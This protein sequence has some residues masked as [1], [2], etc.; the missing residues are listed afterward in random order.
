MLLEQIE[1][2]KYPHTRQGAA[3]LREILKTLAECGGG[4][5]PA[6]VAETLQRCVVA[7][8]SQAEVI[9]ELQQQVAALTELA[10]LTELVAAAETPA[11]S[12]EP[13]AETPAE[14]SEPAAAE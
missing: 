3:L 9:R 7:V 2:L 4:D 11:E 8:Q 5:V 6:A 13:A 12:S 1:Q 10:T 14:S